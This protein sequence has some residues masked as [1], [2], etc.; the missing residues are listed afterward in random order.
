MELSYEVKEQRR[1][2]NIEEKKTKSFK[3]KEEKPMY[4]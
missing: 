2:K 4:T 1:I 3:N